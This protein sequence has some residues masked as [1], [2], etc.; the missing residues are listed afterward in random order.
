MLYVQFYMKRVLNIYL[1]AESVRIKDWLERDDGS[2]QI[3]ELVDTSSRRMKLD[4]LITND[5]M[6]ILG[7]F[8]EMQKNE[9]FKQRFNTEVYGR[10]RL[11]WSKLLEIY[12][13]CQ[14]TFSNTKRLIYQGLL[15][16]HYSL[17]IITVV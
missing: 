11:S 2:M 15:P 1:D 13:L 12:Q 3:C 14:Q 10:N 16:I 17:C 6:D 4:D 7:D 8:C 5:M 9:I